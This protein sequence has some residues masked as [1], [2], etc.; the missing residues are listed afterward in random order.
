MPHRWAQLDSAARYF[1]PREEE[2]IK[3]GK[4]IG[5]QLNQAMDNEML[6]VAGS[7]KAACSIVTNKAKA[8][9]SAEERKREKVAKKRARGLKKEEQKK[10]KL[11]EK[12][13]EKKGKEGKKD[14][15]I[16]SLRRTGEG[17][18]DYEFMPKKG[19]ED[20]AKM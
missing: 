15:L 19:T 13:A 17:P 4:E 1:L 10:N 5:V 11:A 3:V 12:L 8:A 2:K 14:R 9:A 20:W 16:L 6:E 18:E 7:R